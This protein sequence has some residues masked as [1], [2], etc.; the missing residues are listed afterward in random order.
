MNT[1]IE[2][3]I[4]KIEQRLDAIDQRNQKV[5]ADKAWETSLTR[6]VAVLAVTYFTMCLVFI[7]LKSEPFY[8]N[9]IVPT[10]GFFLSTLS[11]PL[12]RKLLR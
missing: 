4:R 6:K 8:L 5:S 2:N 1:E 3:R 9:A 10:L 12:I 7:S 11:L